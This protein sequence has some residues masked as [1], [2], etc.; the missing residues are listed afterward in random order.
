M[1]PGGFNLTLNSSQYI[2]YDFVSLRCIILFEP[3]YFNIDGGAWRFGQ[4]FLDSHY[5][6]FDEDNS[7]IGF[8]Q[9]TN[10][11]L[12]ISPTLF[13]SACAE[14]SPETY[15][16]AETQL[17]WT[18]ILGIIASCLILLALVGYLWYYRFVKNRRKNLVLPK[19]VVTLR[20]PPSAFY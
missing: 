20:T 6:I 5:T 4:V 9:I 3:D 15:I 11:Y 10:N 19:A 18:V 2:K 16:A 14:S 1:Y 7:R 12:K 13:D 17:N 8:V